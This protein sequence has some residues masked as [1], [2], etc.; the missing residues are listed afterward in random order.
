MESAEISEARSRQLD[1]IAVA[2]P[3]RASMLARLFLTRT[4][5][6]LSQN[7]LGVL[8]SLST[9]SRRI[10]ELAAEE[11]ITQPGITL[12]VNRLT[13]RGWVTRVSDPSD[14]RAVLVSLTVD[15]AQAFERLRAEYRAMLSEEMASLDDGDIATLARSIDILDQVISRIMDH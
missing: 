10:T 3:Q 5:I 11:R 9:G 12:L 8:R 13:D 4:S 1:E 14:G 2:L 7:E 6:R 15:G